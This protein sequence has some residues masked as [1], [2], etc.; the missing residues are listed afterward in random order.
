MLTDTPGA[1]LS[2]T[3]SSTSTS[4]KDEATK[5]IERP[6]LPAHFYSIEYP[7]YVKASS[8]PLATE[9][10]GGQSSIDAA[11]RRTGGKSESTLELN[12]RPDNP[13]SHPVHGEVVGTNNILLKVVKRRKRRKD[14]EIETVGEYTAEAIGVIPKTGR[15]R[16]GWCFVLDLTWLC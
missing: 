14:G 11:F 5:A 3:T 9:R 7:G 4:A 6:L 13:F 10:L 2:R 8:V 15:F 16:S 1:G 12:F